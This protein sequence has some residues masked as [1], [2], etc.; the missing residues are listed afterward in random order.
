MRVL[1]DSGITTL[2]NAPCVK[3][4]SKMKLVLSCYLDSQ[5]SLCILSMSKLV[6]PG[7][8]D[9]KKRL[10]TMRE[11]WVRS[12]GREDSPGDGNG[13]PLQ[14]SCLENL[15]DGEAW[16]ATVHGVA[17]LD[18][19]EQLHFHFQAWVAEGSVTYSC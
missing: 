11:T 17:E 13:N 6:F 18:T 4:S 8:S 2:H 15:M 16:Q 5:L 9:G 3:V 19:A 14:Y 1:G 7:G 12:L 10:P